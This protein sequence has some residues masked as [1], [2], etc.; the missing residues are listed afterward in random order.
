[1]GSHDYFLN[2]LG[3]HRVDLMMITLSTHSEYEVHVLSSPLL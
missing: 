2:P 1:M 3:I